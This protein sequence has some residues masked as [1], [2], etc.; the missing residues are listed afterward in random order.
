MQKQAKTCWLTNWQ[1]HYNQVNRFKPPV[2]EKKYY[3]YC[4]SYLTNILSTI[5]MQY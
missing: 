5:E 2:P 1:F 3:V 4:C